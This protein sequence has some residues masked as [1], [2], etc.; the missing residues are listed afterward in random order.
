MYI[1]FLYIKKVEIQPLVFYLKILTQREP[2]PP[3]NKQQKPN[4]YTHSS[5]FGES[6]LRGTCLPLRPETLSVGN[7]RKILSFLYNFFKKIIKKICFS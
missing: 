1:S 2:S 7:F 4:R 5:H 3:Q 6:T